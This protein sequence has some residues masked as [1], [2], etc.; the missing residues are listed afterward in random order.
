MAKP[1]LV[2]RL[3]RFFSAG[4][5][6]E[7]IQV[8]I[9]HDPRDSPPWTIEFLAERRTLLVRSGSTLQEALSSSL[10]A[11]DEREAAL[12]G[13]GRRPSLPR[14]PGPETAS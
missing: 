10:R 4:R 8:R 13:G 2:D 9:V 12:R 14:G 1:S 3:H 11:L 7:A 5:A 6:D